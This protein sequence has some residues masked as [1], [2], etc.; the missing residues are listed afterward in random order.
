M[1]D[2]EVFEDQLVKFAIVPDTARLQNKQ[3]NAKEKAEMKMGSKG[4]RKSTNGESTVSK[5][6]KKCEEKGK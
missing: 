5:L 2:E 3:I 6:R 1:L 4:K